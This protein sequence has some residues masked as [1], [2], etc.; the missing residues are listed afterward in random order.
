MG[1]VGMQARARSAGGGLVFRSEKGKGLTIEV[2]VPARGAA[3]R[4]EKDPHL[5]GG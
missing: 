1:L 4:T 5:V 2:G 3:Q